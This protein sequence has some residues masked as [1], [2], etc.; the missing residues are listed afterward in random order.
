MADGAR[1]SLAYRKARAEIWAGKVP[2][3]YTRLLPYIEGSPILE[4]GSAEGVLALLLAKRG[5]EVAGLELRSERHRDA[6]KLKAHWGIE[7]CH[8]FLGDIRECVDLMAGVETLVAVRTIYYLREDAPAILAFAA[9]YGIRRVVLCGNRNRALRHEAH[10]NDEQG[11][12]NKPASIGGM[13]ELLER[14]G[15]RVVMIVREGDPIVVGC[16]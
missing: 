12:F 8:F 10:P 11:R 13:R 14:A 4:I 5:A 15:Y 16:R 3:K 1:G 9:H 6:L 2:E 7:R